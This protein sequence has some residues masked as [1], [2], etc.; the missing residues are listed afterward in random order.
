MAIESS[1]PIQQS[2]GHVATF[3][4]DYAIALAVVG[5][6]TVAVIEAWKTLRLSHGRFHRESLLRWLQ[7]DAE[8]KAAAPYQHSGASPSAETSLPPFHPGRAFDQLLHL[9]TGVGNADAASTTRHDKSMAQHHHGRFERSLAQALFELPI[10]RQMG[11]IQDAADAALH[12][13]RRHADLFQFLTR[14]ASDDD[15]AQW[16][17]DVDALGGHAQA[18]DAQRKDTAE[19]YT[20]LKHQVRRHLD[21][22]QIVTA[23]RWREGNLKAMAVVG[24]LLMLMVQLLALAHMPDG[25]WKPVGVYLAQFSPVAIAKLLLIATFGGVLAPVVKDLIDALR[26]GRGGV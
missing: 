7:N 17:H 21:S 13:P 11:Q 19:R 4:V 5:L 8:R 10:E 20:R 6:L 23:L 26:K 18:S 2:L 24:A 25:S 22:F 14:S 16:L 9:A 1:G 15:V 12:N 3:L